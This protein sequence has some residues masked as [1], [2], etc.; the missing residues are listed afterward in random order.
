MG[1]VLECDVSHAFLMQVCMS[2]VLFCFKIKLPCL[3]SHVAKSEMSDF[4]GMKLECRIG[5]ARGLLLSV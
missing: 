4:T 1:F 3:K 5:V 2:L